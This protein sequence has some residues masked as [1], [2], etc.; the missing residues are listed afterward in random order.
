VCAEAGDLI[1]W[2]SRTV[3][4]NVLPVGENVRAVICKSCFSLWPNPGERKGE[5]LMR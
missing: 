4:F 2:D 1:V 5:R 3:H